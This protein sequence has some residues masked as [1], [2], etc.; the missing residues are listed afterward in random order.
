METAVITTSPAP[1]TRHLPVMLSVV[2]AVLR[3]Q[4]G[5][6]F[7]D[8][9]VGGG[10]HAAALLEASTPTGRLFGLDRDEQ[11]LDIAARRLASFSGR[12]MLLH[13]NFSQARSVL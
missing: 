6:D 9:T 4:P 12:F 1:E 11:A 7:L 5:T 10:G 2:F 8:G 13:E 3:P